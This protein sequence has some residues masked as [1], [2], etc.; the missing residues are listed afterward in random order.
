VTTETNSVISMEYT[1]RP[2]KALPPPVRKSFQ[3]N[4]ENAVG[5]PGTFVR[6]PTL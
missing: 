6:S 5:V 3:S 4:R 1:K 2:R